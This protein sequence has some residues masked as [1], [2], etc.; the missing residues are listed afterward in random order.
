MDDKT[1]EEKILINKWAFDWWKNLKMKN[2]LVPTQLLR[3]DWEGQE[4]Q[5]G[6]PCFEFAEKEYLYDPC[7][8]CLCG[9]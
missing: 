8:C 7:A 1:L 2:K 6:G 9:L 4:L 3:M 5:P